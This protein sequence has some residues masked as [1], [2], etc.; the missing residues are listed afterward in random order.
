MNKCEFCHLS[1]YVNGKC[2]CPY[3]E[4]LLLQE[5]NKIKD[6]LDFKLRFAEMAK[7]TAV[8]ISKEDA[9]LFQALIEVL[10]KK[11]EEGE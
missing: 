4:C 2:V 8:T 10:I 1:K 9:Y 11:I 5:L 3:A 6:A 7:T